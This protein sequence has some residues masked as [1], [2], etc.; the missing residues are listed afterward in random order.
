MYTKPRITFK[1]FLL[2]FTVK[3]FNGRIEPVLITATKQ[4][5]RKPRAVKSKEDAYLLELFA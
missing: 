3:K 4:D 5:A 2:G 1:I